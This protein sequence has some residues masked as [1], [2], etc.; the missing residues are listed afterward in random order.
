MTTT[1]TMRQHALLIDHADYDIQVSST[2]PFAC[3]SLNIDDKLTMPVPFEGDYPNYLTRATFNPNVVVQEIRPIQQP[4]PNTL[5]SGGIYNDTDMTNPALKS[6]GRK[7]YPI[8][9]CS[10]DDEFAG[11]HMPLNEE[12]GLFLAKPETRNMIFDKLP[13]CFPGRTILSNGRFGFVPGCVSEYQP[14]LKDVHPS[15]DGM[16]LVYHMSKTRGQAIGDPDLVSLA[17]YVREKVTWTANIPQD[18]LDHAVHWYVNVPVFEAFDHT[19]SLMA[20]SSAEK[21]SFALEIAFLIFLIL[22]EY[23]DIDEDIIRPQAL[24]HP[25]RG[26]IFL[27]PG[28]FELFLNFWKWDVYIGEDALVSVPGQPSRPYFDF[29]GTVCDTSDNIRDADVQKE[30]SRY[31]QEHRSLLRRRGEDYIKFLCKFESDV[32]RSCHVLMKQLGVPCRPIMEAFIDD[33]DF[34]ASED[35]EDDDEDMQH[36]FDTRT[37][38]SYQASHRFKSREANHTIIKVSSH[39]ILS[40]TFWDEKTQTAIP[41]LFQNTSLEGKAVADLLSQH[42]IKKFGW[43]LDTSKERKK[44]A[45]ALD[46]KVY[47]EKHALRAIASIRVRKENCNSELDMYTARTPLYTGTPKN[48]KD[49]RKQLENRLNWI[50]VFNKKEILSSI[51]F[52]NISKVVE[53]YLFEKEQ[54]MAAKRLAMN[55]E[56]YQSIF[57]ASEASEESK[58]CSSSGN[59]SSFSSDAWKETMANLEQL[60]PEG[61]KYIR[62]AIVIRCFENT[63]NTV[64]IS[65]LDELEQ[66][67][68]LRPYKVVRMSDGLVTAKADKAKSHLIILKSRLP[69]STLRCCDF[70]TDKGRYYSKLSIRLD[71]YG[72]PFRVCLER[73]GQHI[74]CWDD[75]NLD[76]LNFK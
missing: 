12:D 49:I 67:T 32:I 55:C 50:S 53:T 14:D 63:D 39:V 4:I 57:S 8:P 20:I 3:P 46:D 13:L 60:H 33:D 35:E 45:N 7:S 76:L 23:S 21:S 38:I 42:L 26:R 51:A 75:T 9:D 56:N 61:F 65:S 11:P 5:V 72:R 74:E 66:E 69:G 68:M 73:K 1:T 62:Q 34:L 10:Q 52:P 6:F 64:P 41:I 25:S 37:D 24:E 58:G 40:P 27:V 70:C 47:C 18:Y 19:T 22:A 59:E 2:D 43:Q 54:R 30:T 16:Y 28:T 17:T 48:S 31:G 44:I 15:A 29:D 36:G 71:E